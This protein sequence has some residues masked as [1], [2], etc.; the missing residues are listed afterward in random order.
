LSTRLLDQVK[1][2][3]IKEPNT[4][5]IQRNKQ[6]QLHT[7]D[8]ENHSY[9]KFPHRVSNMKKMMNSTTLWKVQVHI[10]QSFNIQFFYK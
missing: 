5:R 6:Q 9:Q 8:E 7:Q 2:S 1:A 4:E 3:E 10:Y